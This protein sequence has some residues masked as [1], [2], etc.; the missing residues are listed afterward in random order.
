MASPATR[1]GDA[2]GRQAAPGGHEVR[3]HSREVPHHLRHGSVKHGE[4]LELPSGK[5]TV[6]HGK[7]WPIEIDGSVYRF[8]VLKNG[9]LNHGEL[10]NNQRVIGW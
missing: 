8:T 2:L 7:R 10:L 1:P 5:L 9:D 6:R 3:M 4:A